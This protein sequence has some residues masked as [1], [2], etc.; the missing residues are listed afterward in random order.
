MNDLFWFV[1][2]LVPDCVEQID[3][4]R[5][6]FFLRHVRKKKSFEPWLIT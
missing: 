3:R 4:L 6:M 1:C 2:L 5:V